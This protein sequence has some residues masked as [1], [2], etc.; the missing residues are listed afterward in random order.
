MDRERLERINNTVSRVKDRVSDG[1][2]ATLRHIETLVL[3]PSQDISA[4]AMRHAGALPRSLRLLMRCL[5]GSGSGGSN[6]LSYLLFEK[7][8]VRELMALGRRD[9]MARRDDILRFLGCG[10]EAPMS[11]DAAA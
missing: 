7:P 8:F 6:L 4:I 11:I 9:A 5:G 3:A 10:A 2:G 1:H